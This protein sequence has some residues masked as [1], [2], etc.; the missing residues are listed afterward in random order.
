M[1]R[2]IAA[3]LWSVFNI[4]FAL[5]LMGA[6][7]WLVPDYLMEHGIGWLWGFVVFG[8]PVAYAIL[9]AWT[10]KQLSRN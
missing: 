8:A 2:K 5:F 6:M 1:K 7:A 10:M 9:A 3:I 4:A